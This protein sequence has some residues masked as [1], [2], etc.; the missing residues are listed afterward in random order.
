MKLPATV[1]GSTESNGY[2]T[3]GSEVRRMVEKFS[4]PELTAL[5]T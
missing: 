4:E 3:F 5:R 1:E 2:A